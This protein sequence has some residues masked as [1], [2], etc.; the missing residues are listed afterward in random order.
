VAERE[1]LTNK[2]RRAQAREERKRKEAEQAAKRKRGQIKS[3]LITF[4]IVGVVAAVVIQAFVG[5]TPALD[6][7]IVVAADEVDERRDA[8]GCEILAER[9][10]LPDRS[11]IDANQ[12]PN[13][14]SIYTDTRPTHSGPH[15]PGTHPVTAAASS[16]ISE[17]ATTHNL[18]HGTI[19]AW[20]DPDT[21]DR[22]TASEIGDWAE[23]LNENGFRVSQAG[24]GIM[25]AP[26]EDP[27]I[28]SGKAV[29]F[30]AWG[31]AMDCD[32]WDEDVANSF[33]LDHYGTHGIGPERTIAPFP[34]EALAYDDRDVADTTEDEA[35]TDGDEP[36]E[37]ELTD[38]EL[39]EL[40]E[41]ESG[42]DEDGE[43]DS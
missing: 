32:E 15:T 28:A 12:A 9:E 30:R 22:S 14:D 33:V 6:G 20:Y 2:E 8:A 5:G 4:A 38:E 18:E 40:E 17:F 13:L 42:D 7:A 39:E 31:T 36:V 21:I 19:I 27:G 37:G 24:V 3:G 23:L 34:N 10:P 43:S 26:Y 16:Q 25:S 35:P 29:A 11:H 41:L 1:R